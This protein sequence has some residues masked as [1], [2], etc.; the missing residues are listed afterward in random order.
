[1][2]L[3]CDEH[4]ELCW[5]NFKFSTVESGKFAGRHKV[6]I[7]SLLDKSCKVTFTNT[8]TRDNIGCLDTMDCL[9]NDITCVVFWIHCYKKLC[10]PKQKHFYCY[11]VSAKLTKVSNTILCNFSIFN[12]KNYLK[13][14]STEINGK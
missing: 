5:S 10:P 6:E 11:K 14:F 3:G 12:S 4:K 1:M 13:M 2:L 9:E 7:V 8:T